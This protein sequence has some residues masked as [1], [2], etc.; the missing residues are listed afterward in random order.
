MTIG[1][2][3]VNYD[4]KQLIGNV[5]V[6][7]AKHDIRVLGIT[8]ILTPDAASPTIYAMAVA[9]YPTGI[10]LPHSV[11]T[12]TTETSVNGSMQI[13]AQIICAYTQS[14]DTT[15]KTCQDVRMFTVSG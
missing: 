13:A 12:T 5:E 7:A 4:G 6:T 8:L 10:S 1:E 11:A 15:L 2:V 9:S 14:R 3:E